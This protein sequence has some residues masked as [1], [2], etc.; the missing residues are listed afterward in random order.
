MLHFFLPLCAPHLS[1]PETLRLQARSLVAGKLRTLVLAV[2]LGAALPGLALAATCPNGTAIASNQTC[3]LPASTS[4]KIEVWGGGGGGGGPFSGPGDY[5]SGGGGG[6]GGYC[7]YNVTTTA[8]SDTLAI[9][10][11][12]GGAVDNNGGASQAVYSVGP[13]TVS[14]DGKSVSFFTRDRDHQLIPCHALIA[15]SKKIKSSTGHKHPRI[16]IT[17][18]ALFQNL[19]KAHFLAKDLCAKDAD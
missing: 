3:D 11:G 5:A 10:V 18:T 6:G 4:V 17:T 1:M 13:I 19:N 16:V 12:S 14:A 8:G 9:T 15:H 7:A 2:V